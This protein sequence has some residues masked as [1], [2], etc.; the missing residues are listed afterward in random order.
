MAQWLAEARPDLSF[1][2]QAGD[3]ADINIAY[4]P[5]ARTARPGDG[6]L[7]IKNDR[8]IGGMTP[9]CSARASELYKIF[10]EGECGDQLPHCRDVQTDR[11]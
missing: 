4:C 6:E 8:V 9:V 7:S 3:E 1:P 10:L 5:G 11:K 2:Q